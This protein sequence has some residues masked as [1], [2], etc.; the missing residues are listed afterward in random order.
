MQNK[1]SFNINYDNNFFMKK[2]LSVI[3]LLLLFSIFYMYSFFIL[4]SIESINDDFLAKYFYFLRIGIATGLTCVFLFLFYD[5]KKIIL[6]IS[7][8]LL[9]IFISSLV[10]GL[11]A[12]FFKNSPCWPLKY[13]IG[14]ITGLL[15]YLLYKKENSKKLNFLSGIVSLFALLLC[16]NLERFL[17]M[18]RPD[19]P[20]IL[21][22]KSFPN[23][24]FWLGIILF[25][26]FS[27]YFFS[28]GFWIKIKLLKILK[29]T[30]I[31]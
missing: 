17:L 30:T 8:L 26:F 27:S 21:Y 22:T 10:S 18:D 16:E 13:L 19:Y 5:K 15:F 9:I 3:L 6:S 28:K 25:I 29:T 31:K 12:Y 11:L 2:L 4:M 23:M 7:K 14:I 24:I 1:K 20:S